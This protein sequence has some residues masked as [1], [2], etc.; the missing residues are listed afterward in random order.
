M[1]RSP[2][3]SNRS[4]EGYLA[5]WQATLQLLRRGK[6]WS[7]HERNCAFLNV[8]A[9]ASGDPWFADVSAVTGLDFADDG[10]GLAV[11]DWDG[12][13]DL[14]LWLAN[15][16]GPRLRLMLNRGVPGN[17]SVALRLR[18]TRSNRDAVGAR[19][20]LTIVPTSSEGLGQMATQQTLVQTVHAGDGFL[21]Q[22]S[23]W[24][25]YGLGSDP[26]IER[27]TVRWPPRHGGTSG[28]VESFSGVRPGGRYLL[29]EGRGE[30]SPVESRLA[31]LAL[32]PSAQESP[33]SAGAQRAFLPVRVPLPRLRYARFEDPGTPELEIGAG[34]LLVNFWATWCL[35][36]I[37]E[38]EE[39]A[40]H[41]QRLEAAGLDVLALSVDG[42]AQDQTTRPADARRLLDSL[43]FP[44]ASGMA[45]V[46]LLDKVELMEEILFDRSRPFSVPASYL[47]DRDGRL[48]AIYRGRLDLETLL[49]D[50]ADLDASA[51]RLQATSAPF[52]GR[53]IAR[54]AN[55]DPQ[56][57][58]AQFK[59]RHPEDVERYLR[60]ALEEQG[61]QGRE[62]EILLALAENVV[63]Q[64]RMDE[65]AE[66]LERAIE[67][68]PDRGRAHFVLAGLRRAVGRPDEA[69]AHYL[70]AI[71]ID[72]EDAESHHGLG[73][74]LRTAGRLDEAFRHLAVAVRLRPEWPA[75]L[76]PMVWMLIGEP[77]EGQAREA[78]RLAE[79]AVEL[80]GGGNPVALDTLAAAYAAAGR[81]EE[82]VATARRAVEQAMAEGNEA[83]A[84]GIEE[85]LRRYDR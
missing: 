61:G 23:K 20:E 42:L 76:I 65:A 1:S 82:A 13:G 9:A 6:S 70:R 74:T 34:P 31:D 64:G 63:E 11:V 36:C 3:T 48:A 51:Q 29:V 5:G 73:V 21:S 45:S 67:L 15:R 58:A 49:D 37:A 79:R 54:L 57:L 44:F 40:A 71:E 12:D 16:T 39:L 8:G 47:L 22:S 17:S 56:W 52:P 62:A 4:S 2:E 43:G 78:V 75:P 80:T 26:E 72:P 28:G 66:H 33:P 55:L 46:D 35:P 18:G 81:L 77:E 85:R 10:R 53:W 84:A 30:A 7:G 68:D 38:L 19:V 27:V 50:L 41:E 14:D 25:H 24:L 60:L 59:D 83:L 69:I 32:A